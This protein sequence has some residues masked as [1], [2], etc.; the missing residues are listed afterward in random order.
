M[1]G[2]FR[3]GWYTHQ[4][5]GLDKPIWDKMLQDAGIETKETSAPIYRDLVPRK[6]KNGFVT[7]DTFADLKNSLRHY[8]MRRDAMLTVPN[9]GHFAAADVWRAV[10]AKIQEYG[11]GA[12]YCCE[13]HTK[14]TDLETGLSLLRQ[15]KGRTTA[16]KRKKTRGKMGR[17][18]VPMGPNKKADALRMF[19]DPDCSIA[20]IAD[21]CGCSVGTILARMLEW[22]GVDEKL[23]AEQMAKERRWPPKRKVRA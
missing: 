14:V 5:N 10:W 13:T 7:L 3:F 8:L 16:E 12:V 19:G 9:F 4:K 20:A 17:P 1:D 6:S 18:R 11:G 15:R 21:H 2:S 23:V 22:T